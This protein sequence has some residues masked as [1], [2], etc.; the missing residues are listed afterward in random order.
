VGGDKIKDGTGMAAMLRT[1]A[2]LEA[3]MENRPEQT[4]T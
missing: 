3:L 4:R 2:E 1:V